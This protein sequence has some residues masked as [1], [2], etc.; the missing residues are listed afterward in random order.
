M[1]VAWLQVILGELI[2]RDEIVGNVDAGLVVGTFFITLFALKILA[3]G[4]VVVLS[5]LLKTKN[6]NIYC[7]NIYK[8]EKVWYNYVNY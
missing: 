1:I 5:F 8:G 3:T 4:F 2:D 6:D 7:I